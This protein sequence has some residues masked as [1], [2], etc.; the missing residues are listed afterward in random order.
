VLVDADC[1]YTD[2]KGSMF[3]SKQDIRLHTG[4]YRAWESVAP[5]VIPAVWKQLQQ[6][7]LE[8]SMKMVRYAV[9]PSRCQKHSSSVMT[10]SLAVCWCKAG[11]SPL[12]TPPAAAAA[13]A[14]VLQVK[15]GCQPGS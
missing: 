11:L 10:C 1:Q 14:P 3:G 6:V 2:N 12:C 7:R 15:L 13:A 9:R 5:V 8:D 4:F